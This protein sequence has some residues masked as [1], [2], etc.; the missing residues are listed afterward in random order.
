[1]ALLRFKYQ[2]LEFDTMDIHFKTLRDTQE[3]EDKNNIAL[4]LG[5]PE[6]TWALFGVVWPSSEVLARTLYEYQTKG[7]RI[8]EV[9]CGIGLTSLMLNHQN[10]D[11]TAT[12]YHPEVQKML[13]DNS[14]LNNDTKIPFVR[15]GWA[16]E[17]DTLGKF[18]LIIGS[19]LLYE[20]DHI[21]LLSNFINN[22]V[23][24]ECEIIL[25]D[26]GRSNHSKFTQ[27]MVELGYEHSYTKPDTTE[28]LEKPFKGRVLKY[29][30]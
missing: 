20:R 27:R 8:L 21:D 2:T 11:I 14:V 12:D 4:E 5:I 6:S 16:D 15:M 3:F 28:Y 17:T 24:D 9:G 23:N 30:K 10:E 19:D 1:M 29:T 7:K 18:D 22:H 25:I 13:E 26:P